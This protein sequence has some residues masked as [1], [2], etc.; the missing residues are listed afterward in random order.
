MLRV[1][2]LVIVATGRPTCHT[3][4]DAELD[5]AVTTPSM[6]AILGTPH[7]L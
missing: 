2:G 3:S 4:K 1:S 5:F 7:H 6:A